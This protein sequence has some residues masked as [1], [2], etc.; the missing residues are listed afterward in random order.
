MLCNFP[1]QVPLRCFIA[2]W[3]RLDRAILVLRLPIFNGHFLWT[4]IRTNWMLGW[5]WLLWRLDWAQIHSW[6]PWNFDHFSLAWLDILT[7]AFESHKYNGE[8]VQRTITSCWMQDFICN[9]STY[10]MNWRSLSTLECQ[11]SLLCSD[12]PNQLID[13]IV[14]KFVK[15]AIWAYQDIV[16]LIHAT[17]FMNDLRITDHYSL[18]S[19]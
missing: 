19:S 1:C 15:D 18:S 12:I 5:S 2:L 3:H 10:S 11:L 16:K 4:M 9:K 6:I 13:L 8:I 14:L 7:I 17:S